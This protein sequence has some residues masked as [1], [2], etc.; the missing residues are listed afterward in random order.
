MALLA[1]AG[2]D[3]PKRDKPPGGDPILAAARILFRDQVDGLVELR[4]LGVTRH[5]QPGKHAEASHY[6]P[7]D[8]GLAQLAKAAAKLDG[9]AEG[10]YVALNPVMTAVGMGMAT[11]KLITSRRWF[12][13]DA[14]PCRPADTSATDEEKALALAKVQAVRN[15]T[16]AEGWPDPILADS[17]NGTH[18]LYRVDLPNDE[19]SAGLVKAALAAMSARWSDD[20]VKIDTTVHN[21]SRI[22]KLYGTTARKGIPTDERPHRVSGLVEVPKPVGTVLPEMLAALAAEAPAAKAAPQIKASS[23]G[24]GKAAPTRGRLIARDNGDDPVEAYCCQAIQQELRNLATAANGQRN[25]QLFK[26][27][28]ALAQIVAAGKLDQAEV[29]NE[30]AAAARGIGLDEAEIQ[31]TLRSAFKAGGSQPRDLSK[32]GDKRRRG[33]GG[34]GKRETAA[35]P[36]TGEEIVVDDSHRLATR[37]VQQWY[38]HTEGA[39]IRFWNEEWH[40]WRGNHWDATTEK[41]ISGKLA[42]FCKADFVRLGSDLSVSTRLVANVALALRGMVLVPLHDC[43]DRP[44]W[45]DAGEVEGALPDPAECLPCS[46]EIVHLPTLLERGPDHPGTVMARTPRFF[47]PTVLNYGFKADPPRPDAWLQF[48]ADVWPDDPESIRALQQWFGYLLTADT[49][50]QKILLLIGPKRSGKGTIVRTLREMIGQTNTAAPTLSM[51]GTQFGLQGL[52]GKTL[53]MVPESRLTGRTDSQAIVERLL[54]ISGEDPQTIDRKHLTPWH[55][56]LK[57]RFVLT[58]NELPTLGDYSGALPG[59]FIVIKMEKSFYG[60]EDLGLQKR[61]MAELPGILIWAIAGWHDLRASGKFLQPA[62]GQDELDEMHAASSPIGAF[63]AECCEVS[64]GARVFVKDLYQAWEA[65][66]KDNGRDHVGHVQGFSKNLK[67]TIS[68]VRTT[69]FQASG[70]RSRTFTGIKLK[71]DWD[72]AD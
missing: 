15:W 47:S 13:V 11:D 52:I 45:L 27:A 55:G 9:R 50:Q 37:F 59:R 16:R 54:S 31:K 51:L 1:R 17:G 19:T 18:L 48:L 32:V 63:V 46:G 42:S 22:C 24:N 44:A 3:A 65:W 5:G 38:S 58:G 23:N 29:V 62:S 20:A 43:P 2:D 64:K 25:A 26:S 12:L 57:A 68:T 33:G 56:T 72:V 6:A 8:H 53:A 34:P 7:D 39:L 69:R 36:D 70:E 14:D 71:G 35:D 41:E 4:A 60:Q 28:A 30:L 67:T 66:C 10:I 21:A 40:V 61:L 49:S